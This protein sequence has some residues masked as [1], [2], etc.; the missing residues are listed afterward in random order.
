[1]NSKLYCLLLEYLKDSSR[2]D[3]ELAKILG[4]SQPTVSR[5]RA[6]LLKD[7]IIEHFSAIP[8]L[9]KMGYEI[10][11]FSLVKFNMKEVLKDF[12]VV[13]KIARS[14]VKTRPQILFDS[15]AEGMGMDAISVSLHRSYGDY[16][17][18]LA[19]SKEHWGN[20]LS[21][22]HYVLVDIKGGISKPFSFRYIAEE[23][24]KVD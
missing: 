17:Q 22:V 14:W 1:M 5:M 3:R 13:E 11:A 6:K 23:K 20:L 8:N 19:E 9:T 24:N 10:L 7:G 4:V 16:K 2:S 15:R 21:E 18:F 12:Q